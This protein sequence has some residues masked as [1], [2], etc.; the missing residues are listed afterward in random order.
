MIGITF[1]VDV[2]KTEYDGN[3]SWTNLVIWFVNIFRLACLNH[4]HHTAARLRDDTGRATSK[5]LSNK[6]LT[7]F[8]V[9]ILVTLKMAI[10][11]IL[12]TLQ[13][14]QKKSLNHYANFMA[15][16]SFAK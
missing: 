13:G 9:G 1:V 11:L 14:A 10:L 3:S 15:V 12:N 4:T 2:L 8:R 5:S 7:I 16:N 6:E